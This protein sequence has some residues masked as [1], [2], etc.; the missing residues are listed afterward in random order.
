MQ[1]TKSKYIANR[2][3]WRAW[4]AKNHAKER[5][6]WLIF[7]KKST[8]KPILEYE[9]AVEEALCF[10][11]IDSTIKKIDETKYARKFTPRRQG[12]VWSDVNI[13][14]VKKLIKEDKMQPAGKVHINPELLKRKP[15]AAADK[16]SVAVPAFIIEA[17]SREPEA[18][19]FFNSLAP[20]YRNNYIMWI[21][22]A[23]QDETRQKRIAEALSLLRNN[24]KLGLK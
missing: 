7:Y 16:K 22:A 2:E 15:S 6:L 23:K 12:S 13:R 24:Q 14:R 19:Q 21:S 9:D 4:L 10:G 11:W 20:S 3:E 17:F 8:G 18:L 5:E 1:I